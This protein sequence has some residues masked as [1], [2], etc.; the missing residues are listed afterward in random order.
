[1]AAVASNRLAVSAT[2][3]ALIVTGGCLAMASAVPVAN[4]RRLQQLATSGGLTSQQLHALTSGLQKLSDQLQSQFQTVPFAIELLAQ[5]QRVAT[6]FA[7]AQSQLQTDVQ[8]LLNLQLLG[9]QSAVTVV[10]DLLNQLATKLAALSKQFQN[11][12]PVG[13]CFGGLQASLKAAISDLTSQLKSTTA[14]LPVQPVALIAAL[15]NLENAVGLVNPCAPGLEKLL[16]KGQGVLAT[17]GEL[18]AALPS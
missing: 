4:G 13:G 18:V 7:R 11:P 14:G 8:G 16:S 5:L 1:M 15:G 17:V 10:E 12:Q 3:L 6:S 2:L 9:Q